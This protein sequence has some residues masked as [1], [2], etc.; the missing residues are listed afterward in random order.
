MGTIGT[1]AEETVRSEVLEVVRF[2]SLTLL[3]PG[4]Y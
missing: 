3:D 1:R 4:L 2:W